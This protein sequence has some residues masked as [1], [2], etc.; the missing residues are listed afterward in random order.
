MGGG[1]SARLASCCISAKQGH[2]GY[3]AGM[4]ET[5]TARGGAPGQ[6]VRLQEERMAASRGWV[7]WIVL[8]VLLQFL[9]LSARTTSGVGGCI[10]VGSTRPRPQYSTRPAR[11]FPAHASRWHSI[12]SDVGLQRITRPFVSA[13]GDVAVRYIQGTCVLELPKVWTRWAIEHIPGKEIES[14]LGDFDPVQDQ[15]RHV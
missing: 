11:P 8:L 2:K 15:E 13:V 5:D 7:D 9:F 10:T 4:G 14:H 3:G 1:Y 6:R 12:K